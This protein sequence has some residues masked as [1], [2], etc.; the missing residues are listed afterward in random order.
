[1]HSGMNPKAPI[2]ALTSAKNGSMEAKKTV[3]PPINERPMMRGMRFRRENL[4]LFMSTTIDSYFANSGCKYTCE[5][6]HIH[7]ETTYVAT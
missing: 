2:K 5:Y 1:M 6:I 4:P 7:H 3:L